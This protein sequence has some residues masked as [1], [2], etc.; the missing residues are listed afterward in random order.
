MGKAIV[1]SS[2]VLDVKMSQLYCMCKNPHCGHT[3]VMDLSFSHTLSPSAN[4]AQDII[5]SFLRNIPESERQG[6]LALAQG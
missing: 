3:F 1:R 6:L 5:V 2:K 4:Q